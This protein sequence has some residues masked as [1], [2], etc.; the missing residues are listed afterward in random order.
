MD[1]APVPAEPKGP[2]PGRQFPCVKC[3]ARLDFDPS[4]RALRCPYCG[5][6]QQIAPADRAVREHDFQSEVL[7]DVPEAPLPGRS[8]EVKC[9]GCGAVVLL[10][11]KV[12]T[13]RC[14]Y[15]GRHLENE[16]QSAAAM[17]APEAVLPFGV[18]E[19]QAVEAFSRW[20]DGLWFAPK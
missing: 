6:V 19:R 5:N 18:P 16:P 11:D 8:T 4:A 17:I 2:P 1:H 7:P 20:I 14:P 15:C 9:G 10:E 13:D 3:G 12:R